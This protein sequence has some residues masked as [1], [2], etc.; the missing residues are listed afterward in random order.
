MLPVFSSLGY[1]IRAMRKQIMTKTIAITS[2]F[3][4]KP[5]KKRET[6][7]KIERQ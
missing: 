4:L 2:E 1:E 6:H 7:V 3:Q 5:T